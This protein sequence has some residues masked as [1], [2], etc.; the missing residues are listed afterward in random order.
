MSD[1]TAAAVYVAV[2][3]VPV[4]AACDLELAPFAPDTAACRL[5]P[6]RCRSRVSPAPTCPLL[7]PLPF[8][9][10]Y[11]P[12]L[13]SSPATCRRRMPA[14]PL[15]MPQPGIASAD[16]TAVTAAAV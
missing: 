14:V 12:L 5:C 9:L 13:S 7:L 8:T 1:V 16:V 11:M 6:C 15:Q 10:L 4:V 3:A 2:H